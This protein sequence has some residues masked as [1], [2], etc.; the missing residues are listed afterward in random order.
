MPKNKVYITGICGFAGSYLAEELISH[1]YAVHGA[2]LPKESTANIDHL[3][4]K[5][6]IDRFDITDSDACRKYLRQARPDY[7]FHLAA[8]ASVGQSFGLGDLTIRVN[9]FGSHN[10]FEAIRG[11]KWLRKLIMVSSSD[12][13]GP[14]K[15]GDLPLRP[16]QLFNPVSPYAQSKAAAE[17][18]ARIYIEQYDMPIVIARPFNHTGPRQTPNFVIPAFSRKIIAAARSG[19][20][21]KVDV[22]NISVR[23]DLSDVRD[24]VRGYRLLAEKGK[25]GEAYHLC[26]GK[27]YLIG[28]LLNKLMSFTDIPIKHKRDDRLYRKADIPVL[29]GSYHK[30]RKD[31]G[32]K[33]EIKIERTLKDTF[34]YWK[35]GNTD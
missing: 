32:W 8:I 34:D 5:V 12:I 23:R 33:P 1:G 14:V 6:K 25:I 21:K 7:L 15:K 30:I 2:A 18:L 20:K 3:G 10:I 24:I 17:Y 16:D 29:Y 4:R 28:D 19:G 13:Y 22:G 11:R 35:N 31:V 9:T 27:A 26:S